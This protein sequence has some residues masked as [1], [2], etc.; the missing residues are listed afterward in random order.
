[1]PIERRAYGSTGIDLSIVGLGGIVVAGLEQAQADAIVH[2]AYDRGVN[3]YDVAPTYGDA[4][5]RLGPALSG[6]RDRVFLA[7]KTEKRTKAEA[8]EALRQSLRKL[9]TDHFDL[10]QLHGVASTQDMEACLAPGGAIEALIE[11]RRAGVVRFVGFSA[12]SVEAALLGM[13]RFAFDSVLFPFNFAAF[14]KGNFGPQ[15]LDNAQRRG[16]ARLALKAMAR[17][18]W[19]EGAEKRYGKCW[20]EPFDDREDAAAALRWTLSLPITAA[21]PPGDPKLFRLALDIAET[22]SPMTPTETASMAHR[23]TQQTPIFAA[24]G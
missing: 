9:R 16:V 19:P 21:I 8:S 11:A 23:A 6:L 17:G 13:E 14:H 10:Y 3:Y 2:E 15:V 20:Y 4:E 18:P 12:H 5:D 7:C 22:F 24:A 1:M